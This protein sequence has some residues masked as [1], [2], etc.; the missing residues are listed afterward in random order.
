MGVEGMVERR[1][2]RRF[3]I[4]QP[5]V[6]QVKGRGGRSEIH[7]NT[8]NLSESGVLLLAGSSVPEGSQV[9]LKVLPTYTS[10]HASGLQCR[11]TVARVVEGYEDR[12]IAI[13][14]TCRMRTLPF[15]SFTTEPRSTRRRVALTSGNARLQSLAGKELT[16]EDLEFLLRYLGLLGAKAPRLT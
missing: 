15:G 1:S 9:D 14:I 7:C 8:E 11:G 12:K 3:S 6:L 4:R 2:N 13:A 16:D 10:P 5:A